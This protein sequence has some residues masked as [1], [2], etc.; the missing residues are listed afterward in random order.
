MDSQWSTPINLEDDNEEPESK[1]TRSDVWEHFDKLAPIK[2]NAQRVQC[3]YC[4]KTYSS[5]GR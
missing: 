4:K 1:R 5:K 2:A 3:K